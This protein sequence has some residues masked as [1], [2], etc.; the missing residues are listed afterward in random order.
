M[1]KRLIDKQVLAHF[2]RYKEVLV[3]L[4]SRQSGKTTLVQR[5][6]PDAQYFTGR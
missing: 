1:Y 4:G 3:L 5:L 2:E 6:F